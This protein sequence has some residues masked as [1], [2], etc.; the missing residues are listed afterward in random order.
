MAARLD[1]RTALVTGAARGIGLAAA[2]R[3]AR[4]GAAV[5]MVD[6]DGDVL[7]EAA[8][9]LEAD[10]LRV[11]TLTADLA[12]FDAAAEVVARTIERLGA[13]D[14]LVNNA[15]IKDETPLAALDPERWQKVMR[16]NLDA[17]LWLAQAA[18]PH[19]AG[20]GRGSIVNLASTQGLRGQPNALAYATAKG[21]LVNMTRC[22]AVDLGPEGIRANAVAPGFIDTRMAE[23]DPSGVHE[24]ETDWFRDIYLKYGRMPL[25]RPGQPDD[26]AGPIAFLAG[27]DSRYMTGQVLVVDGGFMCTY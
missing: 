16:I 8:A 13:L 26:V 15:A 23:F 2:E 7:A 10:G 25:R 20:S 22:L 5:A 4:D 18:R 19:L 9:P 21:G 12:R 6:V 1:G 27:D 3:L 24:H 11:A 17:A 14:V